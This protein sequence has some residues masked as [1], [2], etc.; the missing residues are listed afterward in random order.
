MVREKMSGTKYGQWRYLFV[1]QKK[2]EAA[3]AGGARSLAD[4]FQ[5]VVG[6]RAEMLA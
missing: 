4:L 1:Q 6:A 2:L 5:A 3:L